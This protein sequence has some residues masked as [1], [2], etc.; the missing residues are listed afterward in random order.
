MEPVSDQTFPIPQT[1]V[2]DLAP[3]L[4]NSRVG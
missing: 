3:T 4:A 2:C 1:A